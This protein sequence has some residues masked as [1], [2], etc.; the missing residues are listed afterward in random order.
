MNFLSRAFL[1]TKE[2]LGKTAL[3]FLVMTTICVFVL[4]G[5]SIQQAT[6]Q[7]SNLAR[8]KLG[9]TVTLQPNMQKLRE[10]MKEKG[11][12]R[13]QIKNISIPMSVVDQILKLNNIVGYNLT[14][15]ATGIADGFEPITSSESSN[16][17]DE[18]APPF[19]ENNQK[20]MGNLKIN[21]V[22][23]QSLTSEAENYKIG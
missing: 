4:A 16:N 13:F 10:D 17:S 6:D 20:E 5:I 3:L 21:G 1:S 19:R 7:A 22:L 15:T 8:E 11:E 2:N 18:Q 23:E 14:T 12:G 9:A